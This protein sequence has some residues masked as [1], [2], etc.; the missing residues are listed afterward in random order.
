MW[1]QWW[2][3]LVDVMVGR[4]PLA[5]RS[6]S[7]GRREAAGRLRTRASMETWVL[8]VH[9]LYST[10]YNTALAGGEAVARTVL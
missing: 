10:Q 8:Y 4:Q 3:C 1:Q 7:V 5:S 2:C 6:V 9:L